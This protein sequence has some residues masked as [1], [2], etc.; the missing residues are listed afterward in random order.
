M[1]KRIVVC[2]FT[3]LCML[4]DGAVFAQQASPDY[5]VSVQVVTGLNLMSCDEDGDFHGEDAI[6]REGSKKP[7]FYV[8]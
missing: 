3:M 4:I 6:T 1:K 2:M 8:A 7:L 5:D